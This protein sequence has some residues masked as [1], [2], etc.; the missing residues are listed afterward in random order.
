MKPKLS[1]GYSLT[2]WKGRLRRPS[3]CRYGKGVRH[4][5]REEGRVVC[6]SWEERVCLMTQ[7]TLCSPTWLTPATG[8]E[9]KAAGPLWKHF[10]FW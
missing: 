4:T 1:W 5:A 7:A 2:T 8:R 10:S 3:T 9:D 6:K